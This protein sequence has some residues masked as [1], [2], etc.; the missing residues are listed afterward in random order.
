VKFLSFKP[1][2]DER[3]MRLWAGAEAEAGGLAFAEEAAGLSRTTIRVGRDELRAGV[4]PNDVVNVRR[5]GGAT[6]DREDDPGARG[7]RS[8]P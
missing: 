1:V 8:P 4:N 6:N 5:A 7:A 3:L 2:M